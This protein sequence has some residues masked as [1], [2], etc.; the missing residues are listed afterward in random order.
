MHYI[1]REFHKADV[2]QPEQ[3]VYCTMERRRKS[4][5]ANLQDLV[6]ACHAWVCHVPDDSAEHLR[7]PILRQVFI[8]ISK[9]QTVIANG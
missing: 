6:I 7:M 8:R 2:K 4:G 1:Q 5:P 3:P 9:V